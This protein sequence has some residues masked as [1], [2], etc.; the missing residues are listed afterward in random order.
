MDSII[1]TNDYCQGCNRCISA[2]PVLIANWSVED[3][4]GSQRI[5]VH[6]ENCIQ[7]GACLHS[8]EHNAREYH[9]DTE[10]FFNDLRNGERISALIAPSFQA[11]YPDVYGIVLGGL[12]H[13]GVRRLINVSFGADI[14]TWGY[15]N[16][17]A[18]NHLTGG[19][20]QPCPAVVN[21]I[22]RYVP[23]LIPKLMP[24]HS[25][26]M[27]AAIYA[28]KYLKLQDKLAFISPCIAK[29][30]EIDDPNT[31]GYVSY[32]LTYRHLMDYIWKHNIHCHEVTDEIEYG[33]GA[34]YPMPGGLK[35]NVYWF[36]G[37]NLF[38]RQVEG[39]KNA[40]DF[41][42]DYKFRVRGNKPLPFMVDILNC[43]RGCLY[44][45]GIEP[46][47]ERSEDNIYNLLSL[48]ER[49]KKNKSGNPY[50]KALKP[51][52]RLELL[53]KQFSNLK[54]E[55]FIRQYTDKS[56]TKS[57]RY[58]NDDE[59]EE[60]YSNMKKDTWAE[61]NIN[62]GACGYRNC[63]EMATA[64][65]NG[66]NTPHNCVH[67]VQAISQQAELANQAKSDFL[68]NMSHEI[69]TPM[70]AVV[71]MC[72]LILREQDISD[73]VR[74]YC[75]NIQNAGRSLLSIINDILDFSKIEAGKLELILDEF[76]IAST[77]NDV[78]IIA[79]TRK[80]NKKLEIIV[81]V[82]PNIPCGLIG[83]ELRIR[84]VIINLV[85]NAIKYSNKGAVVITI[86]QEQIENRIE[87]SISVADSGIGIKEEDLTKIFTSFQQVDTKRNRA[88]EGTGLGLAISKRLVE[89]MG[90]S[91]N[92]RSVYG[93]GSVF[94]FKIPLKVSNNKPFIRVKNAEAIRV[95]G[96]LG[97]QASE[98]NQ[99]YKQMFI[100][101]GKKLHI[102]V[103]P[104]DSL[105][106]LK[107]AVQY[108]T[109][110]HL[111]V[112]Q[113]I[114]MSCPEFFKELSENTQVIIVQDR[115]TAFDLPMGIQ[116]LY[117]PFYAMSLASVL[118]NE[119]V[120]TNLN[121]LKENVTRFIAPAARILIV[122]DNPLNLSVAEGLMRPYHMQVL[123]A[124]S[125]KA[126]ITMLQSKD[127]DLVFMDH[128]MPVMDGVE[129]TQAIRAM[130]GEYYQK[131]PIIAL[132]ANAI[133]GVRKMF[134]NSGFNDFLAKPIE[135]SALDRALKKWLSQDLIQKQQEA[136]A[137]AEEQE[138]T[139]NEDSFVENDIFSTR[140]GISYLGGNV[141]IYF[142]ILAKYANKGPEKLEEIRRLFEIRDWNNYVIEVHALKSTSLT[143]GAK[144]LSELAKELEIAGK[145]GYYSLIE[146]KND[147]LLALYAKVINIAKQQSDAKSI[148]EKIEEESN[149]LTEITLDQLKEYIEQIK[150]ACDD[151]DGNEVDRICQEASAYIISGKPL[152]PYFD[153]VKADADDFEYDD[154]IEKAEG[155]LEKIKG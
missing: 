12:K 24:I 144:K 72:E 2:C 115:D 13:F 84:Q 77:L 117:E 108:T 99:E 94:S 83:D 140:L 69:R 25:P 4:K 125:G 148:Q 65:F 78:I 48:K 23:E 92:V 89:Q 61:R 87:L 104:F 122:D 143:I 8:C 81:H 28:K 150:V 105:E 47:K 6:G 71:G 107:D 14:T 85:T 26:L 18:Q 139:V 3:G 27:C 32:N 58:P 112:S 45:T 19:I 57:V 127:I 49:S 138:Q 145:N 62:C 38:I 119:N 109:F 118:N 15:I 60:I 98:W 56:E 155:I 52:Q 64:I 75:Y 67:Y 54:L 68:A 35:E 132:T 130:E 42:E 29:K 97:S 59:L 46:S 95:A 111:F 134:L 7:C 142:D 106:L 39:V 113:E 44:G 11:N 110:T 17:I 86:T 80:G 114:Y 154:A 135:V 128:M 66:S 30:A 149:E 126:A 31:Y 121:T 16:Y 53:N 1:Y 101:L 103:S 82:D 37:E 153:A 120:M 100:E 88:V 76:N 136:E 21:Y 141:E 70:N 20:A 9:D 137:I 10:R 5:E 152:K 55:D 133:V 124:E 36:C 33:L 131:L 50:S 147:A 79:C 41:L 93:K 96:C 146:E 74:E 116:C 51:E 73:T 63:H 123:S 91:I 22:E 90:G 102:D 40:Y 129:T 43:D 34:I 151:M